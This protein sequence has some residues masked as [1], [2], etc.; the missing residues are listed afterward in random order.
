MF[1]LT[2]ISKQKWKNQNSISTLLVWKCLFSFDDVRS[3][4]V[5]FIS[6]YTSVNLKWIL[7][8]RAACVFV[9]NLR[10]SEKLISL[11]LSL[12]SYMIKWYV[13]VCV[14][15]WKHLPF[16]FSLNIILCHYYHHHYH[17]YHYHIK[18]EIVWNC[19]G[20]RAKICVADAWVCGCI[21]YNT[22]DI[23]RVIAKMTMVTMMIIMLMMITYSS[24]RLTFAWQIQQRNSHSHTRK[25]TFS[26][27]FVIFF[28]LWHI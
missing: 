15:V 23:R 21:W 22:D 24:R 16:L 3:S 11:S 7:S 25:K 12:F 20:E 9:H 28:V 5:S 8:S 2:R 19:N 1:R 26:L 10:S 18:N 27:F 4:R 14:C 6:S 13:H 17:Y